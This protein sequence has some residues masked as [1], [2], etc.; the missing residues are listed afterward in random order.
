MTSSISKSS[1]FLQF[2]KCL[3]YFGSIVAKETK[4]I[5]ELEEINGEIF[6][7]L[8]KLGRH[9]Y[10]ERENLKKHYAK[11]ALYV[12]K[13]KKKHKETRKIHRKFFFLCFRLNGMRKIA[14]KTIPEELRSL[15][16]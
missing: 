5:P 12:L 11:I 8:K 15:S 10:Q 4:D 9:S 16:Q 14:E 7:I 3:I 6:S 1:F 13:N 2:Q